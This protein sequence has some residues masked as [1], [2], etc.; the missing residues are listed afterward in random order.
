MLSSTS[1][2]AL[3][4]AVTAESDFDE[5]TL[6]EGVIEVRVAAELNAVEPRNDKTNTVEVVVTL[7]TEWNDPAM[8]GRGPGD[9]DRSV[10]AYVAEWNPRLEANNARSVREVWEPDV[11]WNFK[12]AAT[13]LMKYSQRYRVV[14]RNE[15]HHMGRF[16]FDVNTIKVEFGSKYLRNTDFCFRQRAP[17]ADRSGRG[18]TEWRTVSASVS[19]D[20]GSHPH[21]TFYVRQARRASFYFWKIAFVLLLI[22]VL[23]WSVLWLDPENFVDRQKLTLTLF[24]SSVAFMFVANDKLPKLQYLTRMDGFIFVSNVLL[25]VVGVENYVA[26]VLSAPEYWNNREAANLADTWTLV[27]LVAITAL[28][29]VQYLTGWLTCLCGGDTSK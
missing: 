13:G 27:A 24:L 6:A 20:N 26:F 29:L 10:R 25:F 11:A 7:Y 19:V 4:E 12:D 15:S 28:N 9:F 18:N 14:V 3:A 1:N 22:S 2:V 16:P 17:L 8:V 23:S 5:E 21:F